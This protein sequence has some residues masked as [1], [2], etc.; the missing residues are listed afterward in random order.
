[1]AETQTAH[2]KNNV[3]QTF[4]GGHIQSGF[5]LEW[6]WDLHPGIGVALS[7]WVWAVRNHGGGFQW[8]WEA[9]SRRCKPE[10]GKRICLA[11]AVIE[12]PCF[13][14]TFEHNRVPISDPVSIDAATY[15]LFDLCYYQ[16]LLKTPGPRALRV[17]SPI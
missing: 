17:R 1:M 14:G 6:R 11:P 9:R 15:S 10:R 2:Y 8:R 7:G 12:T 5:C 16:A 3:N 4:W 13:G